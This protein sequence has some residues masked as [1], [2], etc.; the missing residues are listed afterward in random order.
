MF[1]TYDKLYNVISVI[2][3][4]LYGSYEFVRLL[5]IDAFII[6]D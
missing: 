3:E 1:D 6:H 2:S 4:T 5:R